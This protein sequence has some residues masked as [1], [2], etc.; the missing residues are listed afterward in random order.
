MGSVG[1]V[2][3]MNVP[4]DQWGEDVNNELIRDSEGTIIG[5]INDEYRNIQEEVLDSIEKKDAVK[6]ALQYYDKEDGWI[7][8]DDYAIYFAY[9]DGTFRSAREDNP[10]VSVNRKGLVG[11]YVSTPD[12]EVS[13]GG[14]YTWYNGHKEFQ[15]WAVHDGEGNEVEGNYHSYYKTTGV[16]KERVKEYVVRDEN[17]RWRR[18]RE[19][20]RRSTIRPWN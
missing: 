20:L 7:D 4:Y 8:D 6:F 19:T 10:K 2:D 17:N 15:Q 1:R 14:N 16:Y 5:S 9:E 11:V 13:W 12:D 18:R 3:Q